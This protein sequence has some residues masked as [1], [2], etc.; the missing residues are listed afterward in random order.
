MQSEKSITVVIADDHP[1]VRR[2]IREIIDEDGRFIIAEE[3]SN[4]EW[5][6]EAIQKHHPSL[7]ILDLNMPRMHG[8]E[9]IKK[10]RS[11]GSSVAIIVMT[12]HRE[13]EIIDSVR[14]LGV[15]GYLL[16]ESTERN[17]IACMESVMDGKYFLSPELS[18]YL[19]NQKTRIERTVQETPQLE[20]LTPSERNV[21]K[22]I[23]QQ[24]TSREIAESLHISINT[25][26]NHRNNICRKLELH[27]ANGLLKFAIEHSAGLK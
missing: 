16:K 23:A 2:G 17:L 14:A 10:L 13:E 9:V 7:L 20:S 18:S 4:G 3:V 12:M 24:C 25:V 21:L 11:Q 1:I 5:V 15:K 8:I 27:G 22:L 19:L 26:N 6:L